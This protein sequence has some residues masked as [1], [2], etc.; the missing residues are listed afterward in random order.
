MKVAS[1]EPFTIKGTRGYAEWT[2]VRV[3]TDD[4][5]EGIGEG[6]SFSWGDN[7][8]ARLISGHIAR[9]GERLI[10]TDPNQIQTFVD[11]AFASA[12]ADAPN[13]SSA[14]SALEIALWDIAGKAAGLPVYAM[15]GGSVHETLPLYAD[16]G[17]FVGGFDIARILA[18]K[19][20]GFEMFKWDPFQEGGNPGEEAIARCVEDV[21]AVREAVGPDYT[22]AI[23]AHGRFNL[24]GAK[25]A[26]KAIEPFGPIFFED[27][28]PLGEPD[29]FRELSECTSI[30]LATGELAQSRDVPQ[31]FL[32]A[33]GLSIW[34][35]EVGNNGGILETLAVAAMCDEH[36][37]KVAP[38]NWCGPV[39]TR[40]A[41]HACAVIPNLLYQEWASLAPEDAWER[42]LISPPPQI[43]NGRL[44]LPDSPGLGFTLD[45]DLIEQ[46]RVT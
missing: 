12:P 5:V 38:H 28:M 14:I 33:G 9:L 25:L 40:A 34:Q 44:V 21:A 6:F 1:I 32:D 39:V 41:T 30:P 35:P 31:R 2:L 27:P 11:E 15:L 46:R 4:G 19:D 7:Q 20:A 18:A 43:E 10:G 37:L 17:V 26:A 22:L 29:G 42:D 36:G 16:H 8:N 45:E 24:Q 3:R 13:W 23:D